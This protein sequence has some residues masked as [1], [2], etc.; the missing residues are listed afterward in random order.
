M[1]ECLENHEKCAKRASVDGAIKDASPC[2]T[3]EDT[4]LSKVLDIKVSLVNENN[5][6]GQISGGSITMGGLL[7][8]FDTFKVGS[9][10]SA[11]DANAVYDTWADENA[12]QQDLRCLLIMKKKVK[13]YGK[14]HWSHVFFQGLIIEKVNEEGLNVY[15]RMALYLQYCELMTK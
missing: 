9:T 12:D 7:A 5:K 10:S 8:L 2:G 6:F 1:N 14:F 15:K 3:T 13:A 11:Y 4:Y